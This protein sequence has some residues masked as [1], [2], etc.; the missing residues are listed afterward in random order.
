M[1]IYKFFLIN[2]IL[3]YLLSKKYVY[4]ISKYSYNYLY[5]YVLVNI[6]MNNFGIVIK[7]D[8]LSNNFKFDIN[9]NLNFLLTIKSYY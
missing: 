1:K 6:Y 8:F 7:C 4:I 2:K 5:F 9:L 3:F